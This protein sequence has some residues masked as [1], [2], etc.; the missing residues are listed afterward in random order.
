M[1]TWTTLKGEIRAEIE[2]AAASVF[3]DA[4]L[5]SWFNQGQQDWCR[6]TNILSAEEYRSTVANQETYT[7]PDYTTDI[8]SVWYKEYA[9]S[10]VKYADIATLT[11]T[12]TPYAYAMHDDA[13]HIFP[14]PDVAATLTLLRTYDPDPIVSGSDTTL[15]DT[16]D[17]GAIKA[18][19]KANCNEQI[20]DFTAATYFR[21]YYENMLRE[22]I[23][24]KTTIEDIGCNE[25]GAVW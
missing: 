17:E 6:R 3:T 16:A 11:D 13:L 4:Q 10:R 12:G 21:T 8:T 15:F 14:I 19:V 9:L 23:W 2:E 22:R 18:F 5:L 1:S 7:L 25:A 20:G 24:S